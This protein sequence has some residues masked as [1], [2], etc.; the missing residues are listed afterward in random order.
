VPLCSTAAQSHSELQSLVRQLQ[1]NPGDAALKERII[2]MARQLSPEPVIPE[3]A[4]R[5]FVQ[6]ATL[7]KAATDAAGQRLAVDSFR[8]ALKIA[9][10]WGDAWY[11][12][13]VAQELAG[14]LNDARNSLKLYLLT[15]PGEKEVRDAQD[16]IY[17]LEAKEKLA[18][19]QAA[20]TS[21]AQVAA[22]A[23]AQEKTLSSLNGAKFVYQLAIPSDQGTMSVMVE[24]IA[25]VQGRQVAHRSWQPIA[26]QNGVEQHQ[27]Q[28]VGLSCV[29]L[30]N[31]RCKHTLTFAEDGESA[32]WNETCGTHSMDRVLRRQN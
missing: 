9:P 19:V 25:E 29:L 27:C 31:S 5:A 12:L 1:A 4:R 13:A 8:E 28:L 23:A 22:K 10:W 21:A 18:A 17:S 30:E 6:G 20:A 26:P 2:Q 14:D 24:Q 7:A 15:E 11:N 32:T 3:E 16:R